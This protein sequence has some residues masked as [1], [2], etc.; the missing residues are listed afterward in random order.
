[1]QDVDDE[2]QQ[3]LQAEGPNEP[4]RLPDLGLSGPREHVSPAMARKRRQAMAVAMT[5]GAGR[6][7]IFAVFTDPTGDF[8]MSEQQVVELQREV[9]LQWADEDREN[10]GT[11]RAATTRRL[12]R[13]IE[14]AGNAGRW[15]AV[16]ALEK[17]L[18]DVQGTSVPEPPVDVDQRLRAAVWAVL[19][20][21]PPEELDGLIA[22][23]ALYLDAEGEEVSSTRQLGSGGRSQDPRGMIR[24]NEPPPAIRPQRAASRRAAGRAPEEAG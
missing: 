18:A 17:V 15:A 9:R 12:L 24:A 11:V 19:E 21:I 16:A 2:V 20:D 5:A 8:K 23:R 7:A 3:L 6:D 10:Q 4:A 1:M 22:R 14:K 13:S